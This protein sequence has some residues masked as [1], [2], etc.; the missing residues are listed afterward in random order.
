MAYSSA[1]LVNKPISAELIWHILK[2]VQAHF[3]DGGN[4]WMVGNHDYGRMRSRWTGKDA[5]GKPYPDSF[6]HVFA[7]LLISLPGALCLYQG[8]ELGL[9]AAGIPEDIPVEA[10]QDPFGK[11]LYPNVKGRDG[12]RTPMPWQANAPNAGFT[13]ADRPWLPIPQGHLSSAVDIQ[14]ENPHSLLNTWRRLLHWQKQQPALRRGRYEILDTPKSILAIVRESEEQR[15]LCL[16]NLSED[17]TEYHLPPDCKNTTG[18]G[19]KSERHG[20]RVK[21]PGYSAFFGVLEN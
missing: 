3:P 14:S 8:D 7:G 13:N 1:L 9:P 10:M 11:A 5:A 16:F 17:A 2:K 6:Y 15:L 21:I 4:C 20:D 12:S 18:S 19:F